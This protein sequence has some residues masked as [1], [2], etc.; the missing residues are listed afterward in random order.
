MTVLVIT[1]TLL[2]IAFWFH[3]VRRWL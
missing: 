2:L 1:G 3:G